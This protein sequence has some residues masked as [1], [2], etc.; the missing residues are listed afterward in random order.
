[1][2]AFMCVTCGVEHAERSE[3]PDEPPV[4]CATCDD[5]RQ[6]VGWAG[7]R[8]TTVAELSAARRT[9]VAP[10]RPG[11]HAVRT[12]PSFAI[13]QQA[14]L[15][16]TPAGNILWESISTIDTAAVAE[17]RALGGVQAIAISHPHFYS[18]SAHWSDAFGGAPIWLHARD[19]DHVRRSHPA[20]R[21][22]EGEVAMPLPGAPLRLLRVGGHFAGFQALL[23]DDGDGGALF[24]GD[25]PTVA[26]DRRW[27]SFMYSYPNLVPLAG[28]EVG[29]IADLLAG[30]RFARLYSSWPDH[31]VAEDAWGAVQR[32][33]AR[34]LDPP[35]AD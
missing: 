35:V 23:W 3:R 26:R 29:R 28:R 10:I 2:T 24:S 34:Y 4:S 6:Y 16:Q 30:H 27:V 18:A 31:V 8:W 14:F 20:Q 13:G 22:W 5:E 7:Q 33:A 15:I 32:S 11:L 12:E 17:L 19:R 21:F 9:V 25:M 1:M